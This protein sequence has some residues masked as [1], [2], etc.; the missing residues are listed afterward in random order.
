MALEN[1]VEMRDAVRDPAFKLQKALSFELERR[2]PQ[3]FIPRYSM[4][5]FHD[6]ISYAEAQSRG[7]QQQ[8]LLAELTA[9]KTDLDGIDLDAAV[10]RVC[11]GMPSL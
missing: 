3:R 2:L 1:Y 4:V 5:M 8:V 10:G 7:Q 9:G 11:E 6:E